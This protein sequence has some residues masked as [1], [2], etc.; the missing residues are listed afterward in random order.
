MPVLIIVEVRIKLSCVKQSE[1]YCICI[2]TDFLLI[3][4]SHTYSE[5]GT[6]Y[7]KSNDD[8]GTDTLLKKYRQYR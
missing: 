5:L 3:G 8:I 2:E 4:T 6:R 1:Y 7:F